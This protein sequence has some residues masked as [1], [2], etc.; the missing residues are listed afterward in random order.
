VA[1]RATPGH[2]E[3]DTVVSPR[4]ASGCLLTSVERK[5]RYL[6]AVV[7]PDR[8]AATVARA[9]PR[10]G[11]GLPVL[12]ITSDNGKE[13]THHAEVAQALGAD[14]YFADPKSPHQRGTN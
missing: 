7:L 1:T 10:Q 4:G 2:W 11:A 12:S 3:V 5:T 14:F 8:R 6:V 13:F 9:L